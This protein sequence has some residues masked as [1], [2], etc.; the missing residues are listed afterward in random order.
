MSFLVTSPMAVY[1]LTRL[2]HEIVKPL[3]L[4]YDLYNSY[5]NYRNFRDI[6]RTDNSWQ[7]QSH[8]E[9]YVNWCQMNNCDL[10]TK[11]S[12]L[13]RRRYKLL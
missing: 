4:Q 9:G 1:Q 5:Q 6:I 13:N 12:L 3:K 10:G 2:Q 7:K 11:P 8:N